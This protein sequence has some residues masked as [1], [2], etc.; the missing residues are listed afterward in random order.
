MKK[1]FFSVAILATLLFSACKPK[2]PSGENA[3]IGHWS[4]TEAHMGLAGITMYGDVG[5]IVYEFDNKKVKVI[6]SESLIEQGYPIFAPID[7]AGTYSYS[8]KGTGI[9]FFKGNQTISCKFALENNGLNLTFDFGREVDG[10]YY[11]F[12]KVR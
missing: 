4:L 7:E 12:E 2:E 3:V 11:I 6:I 10:P 9:N 5:Q 1:T 8:I